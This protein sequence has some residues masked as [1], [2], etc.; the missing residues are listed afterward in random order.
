MAYFQK[1]YLYSVAPKTN[2]ALGGQFIYG[3]AGANIQTGSATVFGSNTYGQ[4]AF[5]LVM[6]GAPVVHIYSYASSL[7]NTMTSLNGGED[8]ASSGVACL[9]TPRQFYINNASGAVLANNS[10]WGYIC[11]WLADA[12]FI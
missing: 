11:Q 5:P 12:D 3:Q 4:V 8:A 10:G 1:T 2:A 9:I 7:V 6:I